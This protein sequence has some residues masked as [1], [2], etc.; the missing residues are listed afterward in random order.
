M[1]SEAVT[2]GRAKRHELKVSP[3]EEFTLSAFGLP[4]PPD[5]VASRGSRYYLW[6]AGAAG[7]FL[8]LTVVFRRLARRGDRATT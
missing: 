3:E 4:E 1:K 6:F 7:A 5:V 8:T 2:G